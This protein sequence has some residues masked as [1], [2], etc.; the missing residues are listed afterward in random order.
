ML[1]PLGILSSAGRALNVDCLVVAGGGGGGYQ[2]GGGGAGGGYRTSS[3]LDLTF[4][5]NFT[6]TVGAGG[7][8]GPTFNVQ[9]S[10]G[11]DSS[12]DNSVSTSPILI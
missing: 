4:G 3:F 5:A 6:V 8:G 1:I 10:K 2:R 9:A 7:T 11:N 12:V